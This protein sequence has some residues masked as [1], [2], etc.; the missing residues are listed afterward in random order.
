MRAQRVRALLMGG[1]ACVFYGA[2]EFSRDTDFAIVADAANLARLREAL[3][4][5]QAE[6]IAVPPFELKYLRR[7]HAIH[8]RCQHPDASRMRVD[9]M[10]KMRGVDSF[11]NL[12]KRRTTLELPDGEKCDLLSLPDLVQAKKTQRDKDWPM[13]RRLVEAH[14]F[15]NQFRPKPAQIRFWFQQLRTPELLVELAHRYPAICRR[16]AR[17]RALLAHAQPGKMAEFERAL[18]AEELTERQR[19]KEYWLPL[20]EELENLRHSRG[21][22][23]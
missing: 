19:D 14:Y 2:A 21:S 10:S 12:W 22:Y 4:E 13:I 16:L 17:Q 15:E 18:L 5:L 6:P 1:Q 8:F 23:C 20:R 11:P 9:V 7:G 3:A